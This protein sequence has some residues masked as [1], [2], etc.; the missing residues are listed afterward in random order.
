MEI[1]EDSLWTTQ[2]SVLQLA[3]V[4]TRCCSHPQ[5]KSEA[6]CEDDGNL[7]GTVLGYV[8]TCGLVHRLGANASITCAD[9]LPS[10]FIV[11]M[12]QPGSS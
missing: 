9:L 5:C 11:V 2:C 10:F 3:D 12:K 1:S 4:S 7:I 6:R 8:H